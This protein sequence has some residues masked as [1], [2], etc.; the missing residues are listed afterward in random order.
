M[1]VDNVPKYETGRQHSA[2]VVENASLA[3]VPP[4][5]VGLLT[6]FTPRNVIQRLV[7]FIAIGMY[8]LCLSA[9]PAKIT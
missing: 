5:V 6:R 7:V 4:P 2:P 1:C 9:T 3:C 8:Y